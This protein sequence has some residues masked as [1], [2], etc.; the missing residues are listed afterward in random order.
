MA[1][2]TSLSLYGKYSAFVDP[3]E[4]CRAILEIVLEGS[5]KSQLIIKANIPCYLGDVEFFRNEHAR[6]IRQPHLVEELFGRN[7]IRLLE[8]G[9]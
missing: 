7:L 8:A 4:I 6:I 3:A 2:K 9:K 1:K 5:G